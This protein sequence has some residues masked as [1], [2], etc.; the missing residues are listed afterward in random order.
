MTGLLD[1]LP[2]LE[3]RGLRRRRQR[4]LPAVIT[5]MILLKRL[6][7]NC[8]LAVNCEKCSPYECS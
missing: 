6:T 1:L 7:V 3:Q 2:H 8:E 4:V 5:Q